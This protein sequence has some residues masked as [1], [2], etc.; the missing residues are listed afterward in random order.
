MTRILDVTLVLSILNEK[1]KE[2]TLFK[3]LEGKPSLMLEVLL[4]RLFVN[5]GKKA[6]SRVKGER[7]EAIDSL[8][9]F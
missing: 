8:R 1:E 4:V 2:G 3:V 9:I 7:L 6:Y 5:Y